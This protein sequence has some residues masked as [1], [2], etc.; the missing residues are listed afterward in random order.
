MSSDDGSVESCLVEKLR[1]YVTLSDDE[2]TLLSQLEENEQE[3]ARGAMIRH[4]GEPV[5]HL[6]VVKAGWLYGYTI[7][8]DGRRQVLQLH[9]PGDIIGLPDLAFEHATTGLQSCTDAVL[10]P[11]PKA[12]LDNILQQSTT[13]TALLMSIG[14]VDHVVLLDRI[15][16]LGR[17]DAKARIGHLLLEIMCRL[18]TTNRNM[19]CEFRL[20]LTQDEIGDAVGLTNV[21]V[22]RT[23]GEL[24]RDGFIHRSDGRVK[25]LREDELRELTD[26]EDRYFQMDTSWFPDR[27]NPV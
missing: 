6:F 17:M 21:Y 27:V 26:F 18:R 13:L 3:E 23:L 8:A 19:G 9:F 16:L 2:V 11:F 14:M 1:Y 15:R 25:I 4:G 10:C 22:S 7:L 12:G 20:P 24:E 5:D